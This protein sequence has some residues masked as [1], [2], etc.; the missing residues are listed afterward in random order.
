MSTAWRDE[1]E[2]PGCE[3][4]GTV[5]WGEGGYHDRDEWFIEIWGGL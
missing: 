4:V 3:G 5:F 1:I 2:C